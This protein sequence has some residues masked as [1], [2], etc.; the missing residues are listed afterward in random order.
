[1][2][3]IAGFSSFYFHPWAEDRQSHRG[4]DEASKSGRTP[5]QLK[6]KPMW[7]TILGMPLKRASKFSAI[8]ALYVAIVWLFD[9]VYY[10]WLIL[11]F[12][13]LVILPLYFSLFLVSWGGYYLYA[14]FQEDVFLA[15]QINDWLRRPAGWALVN[16]SKALIVNNP[17]WTFAAIA[18]WWSPLHAYIFTRRDETFG[19][20]PFI[21]TIAKGS[22]VCAFFWGVVAESALLLWELAKLL[23]R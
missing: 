7:K 17:G 2:E 20:A 10:P 6:L 19:L 13:Y 9:Y 23:V 1:V 8:Y 3:A 22:L 14:Y 11:K 15:D 18:A 21:K 5:K 4:P 12:R 16:R